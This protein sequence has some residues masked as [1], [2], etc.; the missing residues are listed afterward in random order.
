M[1]LRSE[2]NGAPGR[3]MRTGGNRGLV[4]KPA[5]IGAFKSF[6]V[7]ALLAKAY[8]KTVPCTIIGD[9]KQEP[10]AEGYV[11]VTISLGL[12]GTNGRIQVPR[13]QVLVRHPFIRPWVP[14]TLIAKAE[15]LAGEIRILSE[16]ARVSQEIFNEATVG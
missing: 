13:D 3:I 2:E 14:L 9:P 12:S 11:W 7:K 1:G 4:L 8:S 5:A 6:A 10:A 16:V 15:K